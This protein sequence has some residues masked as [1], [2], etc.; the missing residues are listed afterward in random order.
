[1]AK[2]SNINN[3]KRKAGQLIP[4]NN[5][6]YRNWLIKQYIDMPPTPNI[7]YILV[8]FVT[9]ELLHKKLK[10]KTIRS[11]LRSIKILNTKIG[12]F[13]ARSFSDSDWSTVAEIIKKKYGKQFNPWKEFLMVDEM[14]VH[15]N[16]KAKDKLLK[17]D[18]DESPGFE[19]NKSFEQRKDQKF[20]NPVIQ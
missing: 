18:M 1:M 7:S 5:T 8:L 3:R 4:E 13:D 10:Q 11:K 16:L 9:R 20:T 2:L 19:T 6:R 15:L 12:H 14:M 17:L